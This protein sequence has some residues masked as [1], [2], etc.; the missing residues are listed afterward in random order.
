MTGESPEQSIGQR[1]RPPGNE[2]IVLLTGSHLC[3][4][5]RVIKEA[6]ALA[7]SGFG[8]SVLG[9]WTD[10]QLRIRDIDLLAN[11]PFTFVPVWDLTRE[12]GGVRVRRLFL[13]V[14]RRMAHLAH[15]YL[16]IENS[17][18][19]GWSVAALS[20]AAKDCNAELFIAHSEPALVAA[21]H[22][23]ALRR[24]VAVDM[25]DWFSEDL[26]P[27][28]RRSRPLVLLRGL[29][30][31]LLSASAYSSCP[32]RVMSQALAQAYDCP[33]PRV[34]Y[35]AFP[36]SDRAAMDGLSKDRP[37]RSRRSIHWYSQTLGMGRG[38]EDLLE[39]LP[40]LKVEAEI[41][42]RGTP[43][44]GFSEWLA[45]RTPADWA[46]RIFVHAVVPNGELLSRIGEHDI[47][48]AGEKK[49]PQSRNLTV[50]NKVLHYLVGGL[51][52]VASDTDG[53]REISSELPTAVELYP[54]G[55]AEALA[56]KLNGLLESSERLEAAKAAS[57]AGAKGQYCWEEQV[58]TLRAAVE[59]S[60]RGRAR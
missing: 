57:L 11:A 59:L 43:A 8:V 26:S 60:V 49:T 28:E 29:E 27:N 35:N 23:L 3:H 19:L 31:T 17:W 2:R 21:R 24:R 9:A 7:E 1:P 44:V 6:T 58:G 20:R 50:T 33:L 12:Q 38:L 52:V 34:I 32:S 51:A 48:F 14:A 16:R 18:Q 15:R 54:S 42:L 22:L 39:A 37:D 10:A 53:Q 36:W 13:R 55:D 47:G 41:H 46:G 30:R 45:E 56:A 5:P 4:N 40:R 25:E